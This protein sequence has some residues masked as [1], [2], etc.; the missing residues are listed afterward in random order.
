MIQYPNIGNLIDS[1]PAGRLG[2]GRI[3]TYFK[4]EAH[5]LIEKFLSL[6]E[7][8]S[9][10]LFIDK[11]EHHR[12]ARYKVSNSIIL[13]LLNFRRNASVQVLN[14]FLFLFSPVPQRPKPQMSESVV[15]GLSGLD[16]CI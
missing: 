3:R 9:R 10:D 4:P 5:L 2:V 11:M 15:V 8:S 12:R 14:L 16:D 6:K 13:F 1:L 7:E